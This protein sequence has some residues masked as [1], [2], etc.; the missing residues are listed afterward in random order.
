[1]FLP[2]SKKIDKVVEL[3]WL[4]KDLLSKDMLTEDEMSLAIGHLKRAENMLWDVQSELC[5]IQDDE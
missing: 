2:E 4:A 3:A 1:M 5:D